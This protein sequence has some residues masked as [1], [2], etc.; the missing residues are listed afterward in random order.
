MARLA[1][2]TSVTILLF[3][4]A[5]KTTAARVAE[6]QRSVPPHALPGQ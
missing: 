1:Q 4:T 2:A 3:A 6:V 5:Y